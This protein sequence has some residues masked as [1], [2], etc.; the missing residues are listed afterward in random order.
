MKIVLLHGF[1][2]N[3]DIWDTFIPTLPA[4]HEYVRLDYSQI[5][6]CQTI[7]EYAA[8]VH[9]EIEEREITRFV[10]VGHSMGG[11]ISLA[12]AA[13]HSEYLAGLGLFHSTAYADS[14]EKKKNRDRTADFIKKHGTAK[15][16]EGFLPNMYNDIFK[17]KNSVYI[18]KQLQD[19][20]KLPQEAL[21]TAT[22]AMK[23]RKDTSEVLSS[24]E[25]PVLKIIGKQDPF[26]P[27]EDALAQISLLQKPYVGIIDHIAHAGMMEAPDE[28]ASLMTSF[29]EACDW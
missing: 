2:E 21:I 23:G 20:K 3:E 26:I 7:E 28:C 10:L 19:N 29:L 27:F 25:I 4:E 13:K 1:G 15:F 18:R 24:L 5:T 8:W 17:K 22:K 12:Y 14:T 6:F 11:Y 9:H 16:I